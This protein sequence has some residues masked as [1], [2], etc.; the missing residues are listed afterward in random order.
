[1]FA[2][3]R[4]RPLSVGLVLLI[5]AGWLTGTAAEPPPLTAEEKQQLEKQAAEKEAAA[6]KAEDADDFD[7][8]RSARQ[9]SW[10]CG[11]KLYGEKDWRVTD[12]RLA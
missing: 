7:K 11:P 9:E 5:A 10:N 8:A 2:I 6:Q 12:A 4:S 1:M 3:A